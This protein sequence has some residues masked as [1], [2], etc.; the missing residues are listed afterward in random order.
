M[1]GVSRVNWFVLVGLNLHE[2][3][4]SKQ[5]I[6]II[7]IVIVIIKYKWNDCKRQLLARSRE[8]RMCFQ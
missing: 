6:I 7:I 8:G 3:L 5:Q 4:N 2:Q 1:S